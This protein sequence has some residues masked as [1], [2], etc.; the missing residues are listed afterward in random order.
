MF[1]YW[2]DKYDSIF[3]DNNI[4]FNGKGVNDR[5]RYIFSLHNDN[6]QKTAFTNNEQCFSTRLGTNNWGRVIIGTPTIIP[7][8]S[9]K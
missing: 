4:N 9:R 1:G 2:D 3:I 8:R 6:H 7:T 5:R